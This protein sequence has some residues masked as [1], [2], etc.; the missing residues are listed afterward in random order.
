[1]KQ[2][3]HGPGP[4]ADMMAR[5]KHNVLSTEDPSAMDVIVLVQAIHL[6]KNKKFEDTNFVSSE[7]EERY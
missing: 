7:R 6:H 5:H 1:M 4:F 3:A 2:A